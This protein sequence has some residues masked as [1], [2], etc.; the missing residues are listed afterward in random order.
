MKNKLFY[1]PLDFGE[2]EV[3]LVELPAM[4][5]SLIDSA[6]GY[7]LRS[8]HPGS[9]KDTARDWRIVHR[10]SSILRIAVVMMPMSLITAKKAASP[11]N[12]FFVPAMAFLH[13]PSGVDKSMLIKCSQGYQLLEFDEFGLNSVKLVDSIFAQSLLQQGVYDLDMTVLKGDKD[14]KTLLKR[15]TV[16]V[17]PRRWKIN[18]V[19]RIKLYLLVLLLSTVGI[20]VYRIWS[21]DLQLQSLMHQEAQLKEDAQAVLD[22]KN[23]IDLLKEQGNRQGQSPLPAYSLLASTLDVFEYPV[24]VLSY[25]LNGN[26]FQIVM[27]SSNALQSAI[28]LRKLSFVENIT[29]DQITRSEGN[30]ERFIL[31]GLYIGRKFAK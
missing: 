3:I 11:Q 18:A 6:L 27:Q 2:Y 21:L 15:A 13:A 7:K 29:V 25:S 8:I 23:A 20:A 5:F 12:R 28:A 10:D 1:Y 30:T 16:F 19:T 9:P 4:A 24:K 17:P 22:Q 26:S 14:E 31:S